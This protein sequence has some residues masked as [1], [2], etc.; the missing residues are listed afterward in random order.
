MSTGIEAGKSNSEKKCKY[1]LNSS[2]PEAI[3]FHLQENTME[4]R[5]MRKK[6]PSSKGKDSISPSGINIYCLL[7]SYCKLI[8]R[9]SL[10]KCSKLFKKNNAT[11]P[12]DLSRSKIDFK[13]LQTYLIG[14]STLRLTGLTA[15]KNLFSSL[16]EIE[17]LQPYLPGLT[18]LDISGIKQIPYLSKHSDFLKLCSGLISLTTNLDYS[19]FLD[20]LVCSKLVTLNIE[21][22]Q[23]RDTNLNVPFLLELRNLKMCGLKYV[24][25]ISYLDIT[26]LEEVTISNMESL[27]SLPNFADC[28]KLLKLSLNNCLKLK[29][30][31]NLSS[32][33]ELSI[34]GCLINNIENLG[35]YQSLTKVTMYASILNLWELGN[36]SSLED[37]HIFSTKSQDLSWLAGCPNIK[38]LQYEG[39]SYTNELS[40]PDNIYLE[41]LFI[42]D[43]TIKNFPDLRSVS[44]NTTR[45][46]N[47]SLRG[48]AI[49]NDSNLLYCESLEELFINS[50]VNVNILQQL[51]NCR[52]I[53]RISLSS[54][55]GFH[56]KLT[57]SDFR[58][59]FAPFSKLKYLSLTQMG[60]SNL[61][62]LSNCTLLEELL[63]IGE[64]F[65]F[66][67]DFASNFIGLRRVVLKHCKYLDNISSLTN[68]VNLE[69]LTT[70]N[71]AIGD[72][73][74]LERHEKLRILFENSNNR[75]RDISPLTSCSNLTSIILEDC[76]NITSL[77][78]LVNLSQLIVLKLKHY[79]GSV[80]L[81]ENV[82][83]TSLRELNLGYASNII[84]VG[85]LEKCINLEIVDLWYCRQLENISPLKSCLGLKSLNLKGCTKIVDLF[86][87]VSCKYLTTLNVADIPNLD[88]GPLVLCL[89]LSKL[90]ITSY[91]PVIGLRELEAE[92]EKAGRKLIIQK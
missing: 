82:N 41:Y 12:L 73:S 29:D 28:P 68:C 70:E 81:L 46:K 33:S 15:S 44:T 24:E 37:L 31:G 79:Q 16:E 84:N 25:T 27:T 17:Y 38:K 69:E 3:T 1:L 77:A 61:S 34:S 39:N 89:A 66:N 58:D 90:F 11:I 56:D 36:C 80:D 42:M 53:T 54:N 64:E 87:L 40:L 88:L 85:F 91:I 10:S 71:C 21:G 5:I 48:C 52:N 30:L 26:N 67:L 55:D 18:N 76:S 83:W 45:I 9:I 23:A 32:L 49:T 86:P 51:R 92:A 43:C 62:S 65:I 75:I 20:P 74:C 35:N 7:V 19:R 8:D 57:S 2:L 22:F 60:F 50:Q 78:P 72:I 59:I 13:S 63:L 4:E 6:S 47:L 14:N